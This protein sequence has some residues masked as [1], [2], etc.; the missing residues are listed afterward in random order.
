[1][2][3]QSVRGKEGIIVWRRA[4]WTSMPHLVGDQLY[5]GAHQTRCGWPVSLGHG[6]VAIVLTAISSD[7]FLAVGCG[8]CRSRLLKDLRDELLRARP[9]A[10]AE[11]RALLRELDWQE[12]RA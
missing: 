12:E 11:L 3:L 1:V 9:D 8:V 6:T 2:A 5:G 10:K 7:L 4:S